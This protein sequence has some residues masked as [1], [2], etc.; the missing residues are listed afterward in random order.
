[1]LAMKTVTAH[2]SVHRIERVTDQNAQHDGNEH[3]LRPPERANHERHGDH[4][5]RDAADARRRC[6]LRLGLLQ[7]GLVDDRSRLRLR[8]AC[9]ERGSRACCDDV[10]RP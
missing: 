4:R 10:T 1:M 3:E 2:P 5:Q 8:H 9:R 6:G 7:N